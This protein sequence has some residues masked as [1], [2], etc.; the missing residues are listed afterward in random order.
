MCRLRATQALQRAV[1]GVVAVMVLTGIAHMAVCSSLGAPDPCDGLTRGAQ[2]SEQP[3]WLAEVS[4]GC[5]K[6]FVASDKRPRIRH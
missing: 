5:A 2:N 3:R 4:V 1:G 6:S